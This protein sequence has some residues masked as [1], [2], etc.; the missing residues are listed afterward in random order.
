MNY[1]KEIGQLFAVGFPGKEITPELKRLIHEYHISS[2]IL[3]AHNIDTPKEVLQLTQ[4]L[5]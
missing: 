2:V 5:Q 4:S 1:K 3:F